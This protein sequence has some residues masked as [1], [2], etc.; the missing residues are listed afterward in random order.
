MPFYNTDTIMKRLLIVQ[1]KNQQRVLCFVPI[2]YTKIYLLYKCRYLKH[3]NINRQYV[4]CIK[5][6]ISRQYTINI[7]L[8]TFVLMYLMTFGNDKYSIN[9]N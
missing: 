3:D 9:E 8:V 5:N 4:Y 7:Y 6:V 1:T 2:L